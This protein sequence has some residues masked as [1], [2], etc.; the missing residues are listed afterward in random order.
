MADEAAASGQSVVPERHTSRLEQLTHPRC[1]AA[2]PAAAD[3]QS[4]V[5]ECQTSRLEH[6]RRPLVFTVSG[7]ATERDTLLEERRGLFGDTASTLLRRGPA[8][9]LIILHFVSYALYLLLVLRITWESVISANYY[10]PVLI[11][12]LLPIGLWVLMAAADLLFNIVEEKPIGISIFGL[13]SQKKKARPIRDA[14]ATC[15][16][17][18]ALGGCNR[19][20]LEP[21]MLNGRGTSIP[22]SAPELFTA[23]F[24]GFPPNSV[25]VSYCWVEKE[26]PRRVAQH[27]LPRTLA[28][29]D[30]DRLIPG[31]PSV[32]AMVAAVKNARF[33]LVFLS[34]QYLRSVNCGHEV[35]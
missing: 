20:L 22:K 13:D 6:M 28:W 25:M 19:R 26:L 7:H 1:L 23:F 24:T 32:P 34:A 30:V 9:R 16:G 29:L 14:L 27:F 15:L 10:F 8:L 21:L 11:A 12:W 31:T 4:V 2:K 33:R 3:G 35:R 18:R 5:P 17:L